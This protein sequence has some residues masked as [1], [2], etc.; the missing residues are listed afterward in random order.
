[1][2]QS[3][4]RLS[5]GGSLL[6]RGRLS[7]SQPKQHQQATIEAI[8][9]ELNAIRYKVDPD[10]DESAEFVAKCLSICTQYELSAE[11]FCLK[12]D[13]HRFTHK[14]KGSMS[15]QELDKLSASIAEQVES[16]RRKSVK[17]GGVGTIRV[18]TEQPR[19]PGALVR[20]ANTTRHH[21]DHA[22][23]TATLNG[24]RSRGQDDDDDLDE[25]FADEDDV[26][27][28]VKKEP[29]VTA[30][31]NKRSSTQM[32]EGDTQGSEE[33]GG[34]G[35]EGSARKKAKEGENGASAEDGE[36]NGS[37]ESANGSSTSTPSFLKSFR[38]PTRPSFDILLRGPDGKRH[39]RLYPKALGRYV[40]RKNA[41]EVAAQLNGDNLA[42]LEPSEAEPSADDLAECAK[43]VI[44]IE[45]LQPDDADDDDNEDGTAAA[46]TKPNK[47]APKKTATSATL[48]SSIFRYM[49]QGEDELR[50][51]LDANLL[52]SKEIIMERPEFK[53][54]RMI[55]KNEKMTM[56][57]TGRAKIA[58]ATPFK[59][60]EI[61][62]KKEP[63]DTPTSQSQT[64]T[65][66]Q[67]P[68]QSPTSQEEKKE[69]ESTPSTNGASS[70]PAPSPAAS[71]ASS[72][73]ATP[74]KAA[75]IPIDDDDDV[76]EDSNLVPIV[77]VG[78]S[79]SQQSV[80]LFGR[81]VYD[82]NDTQSETNTNNEVVQKLTHQHSVWMEGDKTLSS[83]QRIQVRLNGL[84]QYSLFPGQVIVTKGI[85]ASGMSFVAEDILTDA[86][87]PPYGIPRS[88]VETLNATLGFRPMGV[89]VACGPFTTTDDLSF[90]P[91]FDLLAEVRAVRPDV[92]ML[93][94]P[95]METEHKE[96][97][98]NL[99]ALA[100]TYEQFLSKLVQD[101]MRAL[102]GLHTKL[103]IVPSVRDA[104]AIPIFPQP[105]FNLPLTPELQAHVQTGRLMF[106][107]N[108]STLR[109]NDVTIGV[110]SMDVL[111][112]LSNSNEIHK[113]A[114]GLAEPGRLVR[115]AGH[116]VRSHSYYP[117]FPAP[118]SV[119]I[120]W[121]HASNLRMPCTPDVLILP[122]KTKYFAASHTNHSPTLGE[123]KTIIVN[124]ESITKG[125]SGG[126]YALVSIHTLKDEELVPPPNTN[127]RIY[128]HCM[129]NRTRVDI[130]RI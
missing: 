89:M 78:G 71:A 65:P 85:N 37:A 127:G 90:A 79:K 101:I 64:Q 128:D 46:P 18:K 116:L 130:M 61:T 14:L 126:T 108:P 9:K 52:A 106:A 29:G 3:R 53:S 114:P 10:S 73:S 45:L 36:I 24:K 47:Y 107:S 1:M 33:D 67:T 66:A 104:A 105:P 86:S 56:N 97:V 74:S 4:S 98:A 121:S 27:I 6:A 60:G 75:A 25:L 7:Q 35:E 82:S 20:Q 81:V 15:L 95:L 96:V 80:I 49:Y 110:S 99:H 28:R 117:L 51:A 77:S 43:R 13:S 102:A 31:P 55:V 125:P 16:E 111:S 12:L 39:E 22:S 54:M 92:L 41:G 11:S 119:S 17:Q 68:I 48:S 34:E 120:D 91:L 115:L 5:G 69:G 21:F 59:T 112:H 109:I 118:D 87:L 63:T 2:S 62:V 26:P 57:G 88:H 113:S 84:K 93:L 58:P 19:G 94:G 70:S 32:S 76:G 100:L 23:L 50:E 30:T 44:E 83:G 122:S 42:R 129:M 103:V 124:P 38:L 40:G 8:Y 72:S 123:T